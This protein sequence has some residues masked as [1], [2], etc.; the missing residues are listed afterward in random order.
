MFWRSCNKATN[1]HWIVVIAALLSPLLAFADET[2]STAKIEAG[3]AAYSQT[4]FAC[5]GS[6]GKGAIPGVSDL[7]NEDGPLSKTDEVLIK[8]ITD[9]VATAGAALTMPAKGGNPALTEADIE[10][11]LAY[12]RAT[13]GQQ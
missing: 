12:L 3:R 10:A 2:A 6:D 11:L 8:S 5:H 1:G 9:G 4:C 13:F 7:T